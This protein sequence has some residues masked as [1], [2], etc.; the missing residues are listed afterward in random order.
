MSA[1]QPRC[2]KWYDVRF[3]LRKAVYWWC[4]QPGGL[5]PGGLTGTLSQPVSSASHVHFFFL[6]VVIFLQNIST[7][8]YYF[9]S[10]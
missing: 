6:L 8:D 7:C 5:L 1:F 9:L 3:V 4:E 10:D 2:Y